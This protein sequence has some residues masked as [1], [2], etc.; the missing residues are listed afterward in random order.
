MG[1]VEV[2]EPS[3]DGSGEELAAEG[4]HPA[5]VGRELIAMAARQPF[6][7]AIEAEAAKVIGH[8]AHRVGGAEVVLD[9]RPEITG[10]EAA[11]G[12]GESSQDGEQGYQPGG[13]RSGG[14][15][16]ADQPRRWA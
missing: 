7:E 4:D 13:R 9:V 11:D 6:D 14:Q 16:H 3:A 12:S 8:L 5:T 10:A 15:V 1:G 2:A